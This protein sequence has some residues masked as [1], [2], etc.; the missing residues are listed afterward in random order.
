MDIMNKLI[1]SIF[2]NGLLFV[3]YANAQPKLEIIGG[4]TFNW[5]NVTPRESPLKAT[6]ILTARYQPIRAGANS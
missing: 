2:L 6:I 4:D 1:L 5:N 3:M